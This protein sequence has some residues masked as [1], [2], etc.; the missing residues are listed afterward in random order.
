[1]SQVIG[2]VLS[3]LG[4]L[5]MI[6]A[7]MAAFGVG[8]AGTIYL[9]LRSPE[10]EVPD[11]VSKDRFD[12][13]ATL[14][15]SGLNV[16]IRAS[17][18]KAD[19]KPGTILDQSPRAG[20]VVKVGQTIAVVLSR[21]P[22][23]GEAPAGRDEDADDAANAESSRGGSSDTNKN[24]NQNRNQRSKNVNRNTVNKNA[25]KNTA[26]QNAGNRNANTNRIANRNA[27][28]ANRN[29]NQNTNN[30]NAVRNIANVNRRAPTPATTPANPAGNRP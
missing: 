5:G 30:R 27:N 24:D 21:E 19:A 4:R 25:N 14:R 2:T 28:V 10:V 3:A 7:I 23:E 15:D 12:G 1:M 18:Y 16:R 6:G 8:L 11:I 26:N 17:R 29:N 13:E 9:S 22:K 20:E